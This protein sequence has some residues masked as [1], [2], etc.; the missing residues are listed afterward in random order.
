FFQAEDGI[1]D[2]LVTG[3]Q[4]CALPIYKLVLAS[5]SVNG[6]LKIDAGAGKDVVEITSEDVSGAFTIADGTGDDS[7]EIDRSHFAGA[8]SAR[9]RKSVGQGKGVEVRG[10]R[11]HATGT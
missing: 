6:N 9:D 5:G 4:T 11:R 1:R 8:F 3:V 2:D 7:L 10:G